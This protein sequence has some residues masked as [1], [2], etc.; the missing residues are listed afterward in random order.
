MLPLVSRHRDGQKQAVWYATVNVWPAAGV[1]IADRPL[2][3]YVPLA[4]R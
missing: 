2:R 4:Q 1:V 3:D